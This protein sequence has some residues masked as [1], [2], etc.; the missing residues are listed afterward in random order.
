MSNH[1]HHRRQYLIPLLGLC[2]RLMALVTQTAAHVLRVVKAAITLTSVPLNLCIRVRRSP[3]SLIGYLLSLA[4]GLLLV[5]R[6]RRRTRIAGSGMITLMMMMMMIERKRRRIPPMTLSRV[7]G[8]DLRRRNRLMIF[9]FPNA[10][11]RG[12]GCSRLPPRPRM[13]VHHRLQ[14]ETE[15][16]G[17]RVLVVAR[18]R[19]RRSARGSYHRVETLARWRW[20][21]LLGLL[22]NHERKTNW[23]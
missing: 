20:H 15:I 19:R 22:L 18:R 7:Q 5:A 9:C 23:R 10:R 13:M 12:S 4:A 11:G 8:R 17:S 14:L 2:R 3:G 21:R 1:Q 6:G 16:R